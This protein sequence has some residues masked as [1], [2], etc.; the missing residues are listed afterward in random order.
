MSVADDVHTAGAAF[1][2]P[3]EALRAACSALDFVGAADVDGSCCA[4]V[5]TALGE[6]Q[7]KLTATHARVL[8]RFDA[9]D[10]HDADGYG[11]SSAWL[12]ARAG[13]PKKAARAAVREMRRLGERPLI[14]AALSA[15]AISSSLAFTVADWTRKLPSEMRA[16]TDRIILEAAAAGAPVE[17][18]AVIAGLAIERWRQQQ[19]DPDEPGRDFGDRFLQLGVTFG[20]AAVIR[21]D[22]TPQCATAAR[23]V[24][25]ALG[26]RQGPEDDRTGPQ[27]F[28]DAL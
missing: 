17:D 12:A 28:H 5:L 14:D 18:L 21:G 8:R 24:L 7:A 25:E 13:M 9:A 27:R 16:E 2:S 10:A 20:G 26:K 4:E 15:G 6:V 22:L 1:G 11:S 3:V 23:A 19:P